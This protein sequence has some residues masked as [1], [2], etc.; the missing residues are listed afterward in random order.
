MEKV[1]NSLSRYSTFE[2]VFDGSIYNYNG[3]DSVLALLSRRHSLLDDKVSLSL[4]WNH[5]IA[6]K[7]T[8]CWWNI[9][10]NIYI[11]R[12]IVVLY[13]DY[14]HIVFVHLLQALYVISVHNFNYPRSNTL[15]LIY[16]YINI[17]SSICFS[18]DKLVPIF[19][20]FL[21]N[22]I[23][24]IYCLTR[25]KSCWLQFK[26]FNVTFKI[27]NTLCCWRTFSKTGIVTS[28]VRWKERSS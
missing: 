22:C 9:I 26:D 24:I 15:G 11:L 23:S 17:T 12:L 3:R 14:I 21:V 7:A 25:Y 8:Y 18:L 1:S 6:P 16:Q 13:Y 27:N 19:R 10:V 20:C 28:A 2:G 5:N 4:S